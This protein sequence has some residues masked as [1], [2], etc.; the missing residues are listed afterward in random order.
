MP[1]RLPSAK[2]QDG[3]CILESFSSAAMR[4]VAVH[5]GA[6]AVLLAAQATAFVAGETHHLPP[7]SPLPPLSLP[8]SYCQPDAAQRAA[9]QPCPQGERTLNPRVPAGLLWA[10]ART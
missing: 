2:S 3:A 6:F 7:P 4:T 8:P 10:G 1:F 5:F 9:A